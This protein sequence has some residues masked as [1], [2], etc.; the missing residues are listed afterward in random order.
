MLSI[1]VAY[2]RNRVIGRNNALPWRLPSDLAHF[3]R[4]TM[5]KPIIM[6]RKTW[7]SLGRPLPGRLNIVLTQDASYRAEAATVVHSLEEALKA[8]CQV[9][10]NEAFVIGGEAI[11]RLALPYATRVVATEIDA[12]IQ[13]DTW[14]PL[15]PDGWRETQREPQPAENGLSFDV[16]TYQRN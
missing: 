7:E 16:V 15:L 6:G 11:F 14:F 9:N 1:I 2:S 12:D 5:G 13:G 4:T 8:A 3:K 10:D